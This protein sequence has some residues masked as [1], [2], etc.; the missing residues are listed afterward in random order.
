MRFLVFLV[1]TLAFSQMDTFRAEVTTSAW[2]AAIEGT[3]QSS[4]SP[5]ALHG[6]L[7]L[8][9]QWTFFGK[10]AFKPA[11]RHRINVEGSPYDFSGTNTLLRTITFNGRTYTVSDTVASDA[12]LTYIFGGYQYDLISRD[13]GHFGLEAGG[14][15]LNGS[16]TIRSSSTGISATRSET[17]GLPLAGAEF[18]VFFGPGHLNVNGEAKGMSLGGYGY[19]F[20]GVVNLGAGFRRVMFQAG[21]QYLNANIHENRSAS[22]TGISPVISGPIFSIQLRLF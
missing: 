4:A 12:S 6:D 9:D 17:I 5:I 21:Y 2:H 19:Y 16:G 14:A 15:Y 1:P 3:V 8:N 10:L 18:R 7:N 11:R 20:Q 13:R 22:P